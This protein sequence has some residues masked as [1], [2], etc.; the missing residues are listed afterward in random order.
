MATYVQK[1]HREAML[2]ELKGYVTPAEVLI[3]ENVGETNM[4]Q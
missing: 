4:C 2:P 1:P 3:S